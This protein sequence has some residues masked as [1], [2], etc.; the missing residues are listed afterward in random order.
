MP[1]V[2]LIADNLSNAGAERQLALLIKYLPPEWERRVWSLADGSF[3][4]VIRSYGTP[5]DAHQR[6]WRYDLRPIFDLWKAVIRYKPAII[7]S[8]GWW[9]SAVAGPVCRILQIPFI[10]DTLRNGWVGRKHVLRAHFAHNLADRVIA[11][12]RAGLNAWGVT[13]D[14]GRVAHN[15]FD[16]ERLPL[17]K[18]SERTA[19]TFTAVMAARMSP[20]K[21]FHLFIQAAR[22]LTVDGRRNDWRFLALGSGFA[23]AS[24][25]A[26]ARDL[27]ERGTVS[28]MDA[29]LE[30]F[31]YLRNANA[32]ILM[33]N[34]TLLEEGCSNS[35]LEYMAGGLPVVCSDSGGN[36]EV[37]VNGETGFIIPP[38][39]AEALAERLAWLRQNRDVAE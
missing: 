13:P 6:S 4:P 19:D 25:I 9:C 16:P 36:K 23:K 27:I 33:T 11:N 30:V 38:L 35:I 1:K 34:P 5:V 2:L 20:V 28:F 8:W 21:D 10:D 29:G 7:H 14:K 3:A 32:G 39:N 37:V 26:D 31:P 17:E 22:L 12:S 24:L 15:G 18:C